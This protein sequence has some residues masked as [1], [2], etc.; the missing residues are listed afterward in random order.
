MNAPDL[1][2]ADIRKGLVGVVVDTTAISAVDPASSSLLY[3]G[4]PVQELAARCSFEEVAWLLWHGELPGQEEL[5]ALQT[6]ERGQRELEPHVRT[7]VDALPSSAH[8]MDVLRTAVSVMGAHLPDPA[9][10]PAAQ[11]EEAV[12]LF[13]RIPAVIAYDQRRR[14][15]QDVVPPRDDLDFSANLLHMTFDGVPDDVVVDAMRAATSAGESVPTATTGARQAWHVLQHFLAKDVWAA[16]DGKRRV[17]DALARL[18]LAGRVVRT[19]YK[20][21]NRHEADRWELAQPSHQE[22]Y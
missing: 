9:D 7:V 15:G 19:T 6:Q 13:A 8:P 10:D 1:Q 22:D 5:L 17:A 18:A 4:Y 20:K 14:R 16:K 12:T 11:L 21:P 2:D 3:R